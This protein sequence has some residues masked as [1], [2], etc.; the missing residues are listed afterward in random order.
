[1][2]SGCAED[3]TSRSAGVWNDY[4]IK[5]KPPVEFLDPHPTPPP[6]PPPACP[7]FSWLS[8]EEN[9]MIIFWKASAGPITE[10]LLEGGPCLISALPT[11]SGEQLPRGRSEV[12]KK[13][14]CPPRSFL[15]AQTAAEQSSAV[16]GR[17][18]LPAPRHDCCLQPCWMKQ[19]ASPGW[20][21]LGLLPLKG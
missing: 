16:G 13:R 1:M 15:A 5:Y 6:P 8:W 10:V 9:V 19:P 12:H 21:L 2:P 7:P 11:S 3:S 4:L 17:V 18:H 20:K 14:M